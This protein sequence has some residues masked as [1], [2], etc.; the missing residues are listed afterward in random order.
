MPTAYILIN[1]TLGSEETIIKEIT[2]LHEAKEIRATYGIHD[3]FVKVKA[4]STQLLNR[5][6]TTK[7]RKIPR[8]T[9]TVTMVVVEEQGGKE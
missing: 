8:I 4:D 2:S 5:L 3:I 1:C 7:I 9:S 6:M